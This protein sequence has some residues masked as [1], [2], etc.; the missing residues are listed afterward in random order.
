M[1]IQELISELAGFEFRNNISTTVSFHVDGSGSVC[2]FWD[3]EE[4]KQFADFG[5]L[6]NF[7]KET[8]YKLGEDGR[9]ISPVERI[10]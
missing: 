3:E 6:L 2:E 10:N 1:N 5:D 8:K 4:L 9:C 7:L